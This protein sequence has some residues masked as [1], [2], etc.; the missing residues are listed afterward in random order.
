MN[1]NQLIEKIILKTEFSELPRKEIEKA[2]EIFDK[3]EYSDTEK[4]KLTRGLLKRVFTAF[5][6]RRIRNPKDKDARWFLLRHVST[7]ERYDFYEKVYFR[8]LKDFDKCSIIDLGCGINGL[9]YEYFEKLG[10]KIRYLGIEAIGQLVKVNNYF[11]KKNK[12][13]AKVV[14]LSLFDLVNVKEIIKKQKKPKICFLFKSVDSLEM[15]ERNYVKKFLEE[16][17]PLCNRFVISFAMKSF[18]KKEKFKVRRN[19]AIN[20]IKENFSILD[21]FEFGGEKYIVF[22][23]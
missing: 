9:S 18:F 7:K 20:Y 1:K 12:F 22:K 2:F 15:L 14:Q 21:E 17:V 5:M 4:I 23:K 3:E 10:K 19:W 8:I 13:D 6:G 11:F 16:I